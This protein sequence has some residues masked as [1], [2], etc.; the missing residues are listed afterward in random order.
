MKIAALL[1]AALLGLA[2]A[3]ADLVLVQKVEGAGQAGEQT[4]R[5][6][7]GKSRADL[8]GALSVI[9]DS[10]TGDSVTLKHNDKTFMRVPAEQTRA[11][12]EQMRRQRGSDAPP[13]LKSEGR[14]EKVGEY[15]CEIFTSHLG[16]L[17]VKYWIAKDFPNYQ[18]MQEQISK[19]QSSAAAA[20]AGGLLPDPKTFPG[21]TM[22]TEMEL[23]K[24]KVTTTLVSAKEE[25]VDPAIFEIPEGYRE[26][27]G[28]RQP[29]A[30][31]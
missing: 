18:A 14:K 9:T 22:K 8:A 31:E 17:D 28:P 24:K 7:D 25:P 23:G 13:E 12:V 5:I 19:L 26:Q 29:E 10:T 1:L 30:E 15:E 2:V 3:R 16:E 20:G 11:M 27:A 21:M 4:I 6:K